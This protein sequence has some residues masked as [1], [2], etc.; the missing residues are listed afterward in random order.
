MGVKI[1][2]L[3]YF[4]YDKMISDIEKGKVQVQVGVQQ[5]PAGSARLLKGKNLRQPML[6]GDGQY[7][8]RG[9]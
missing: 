5:P 3:E 9:K 4:D 8:G 7:V 6:R 1:K 2:R